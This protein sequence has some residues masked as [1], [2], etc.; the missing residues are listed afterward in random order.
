M[1]Q[2]TVA[3]SDC[4]ALSLNTRCGP[5]AG[6]SPGRGSA[7]PP[8][9]YPRPGPAPG[10][11]HRCPATASTCRLVSPLLP[12]PTRI[13]SVVRSRGVHC[14]V[15]TLRALVSICGRDRD[16]V[17][18]GPASEPLDTVQARTSRNTSRTAMKTYQHVPWIVLV[19]AP[20]S[21]RGSRVQTA[22]A[23][24]H[25]KYKTRTQPPRQRVST[26]TG[27]TFRESGSALATNTHE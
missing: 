1:P 27:A 11:Q 5:A 7:P 2:H 18:A 10:T 20:A 3:A 6:P 9:P 15:A 12:P 8:P 19:S 14:A 22:Q 16:G 17:A 24:S 25:S 23:D 4:S 13:R 21:M 26:L